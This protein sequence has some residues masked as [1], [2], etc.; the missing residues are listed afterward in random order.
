MEF[1]NDVLAFFRAGFD[2]VNGV[3]GLIIAFVAALI[4]PSWRRLPMFT[5]G[6]TIIHVLVDSLL[7][8]VS[9]GAPLLLPDILEYPFWRYVAVL[10]AGYLVVIAV[11]MLVRQL[12]L[13]R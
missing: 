12:L 13:K 11:F 6:A 4:L 2:Q 9:R 1:L 3:Q 8:V 7:P 5:L 10:L